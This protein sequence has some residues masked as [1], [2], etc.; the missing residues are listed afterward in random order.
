MRSSKQQFMPFCLGWVGV[1]MP[2]P[3]N[4]THAMSLSIQLL[5]ICFGVVILIAACVLVW[6]TTHNVLLGCWT[7]ILSCPAQHPAGQLLLWYLL[8]L[9]HL[10]A[11]KINKFK[12]CF[13]IVASVLCRYPLAV[14]TLFVHQHSSYY[15]VYTYSCFKHP[16]RWKEGIWASLVPRW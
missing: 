12:D 16:P 3:I 4:A 1:H 7:G 11:V 2:V 15:D 8:V 10:K 9:T 6:Q 5:I 13:G 14:C